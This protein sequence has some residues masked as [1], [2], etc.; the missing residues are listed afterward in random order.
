MKRSVPVPVLL[1]SVLLTA[2]A[3]AGLMSLARR[4]RPPAEPPEQAGEFRSYFGQEGAV[5]FPEPYASPP[6]VRLRNTRHTA[7]T[8]VSPTGFRWKNGGKDANSDT[9][10]RGQRRVLPRTWPGS[11]SGLGEVPTPSHHPCAARRS[12]PVA[13]Q[14][15]TNNPT[16]QWVGLMTSG[17]VGVWGLNFY[18]TSVPGIDRPGRR[19]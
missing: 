11:A 4:D 15:E 18:R 12:K 5:W 10:A 8:E 17:G 13:G 14:A 6:Y 3:T 7:V 2:A 1:L 16:R 9:L 19:A